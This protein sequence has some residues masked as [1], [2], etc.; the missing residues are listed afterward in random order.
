MRTALSHTAASAP[1]HYARVEEDFL[2]GVQWVATL[3]GRTTPACQVRDG[4][5][6]DLAHRPLGHNVP[7]LAGPGRLHWNCRSTSVPL[8]KSWREL[9]V[10]MNEIDPSTHAS[11]DG[12]VPAEITYREWLGAQSTQRQDE[13]LGSQRGR[14]LREG[15]LPVAAL[16][17]PGPLPHARAAARAQRA[18][19]RARWALKLQCSSIQSQCPRIATPP[20]TV[21]PM[22]PAAARRKR[23]ARLGQ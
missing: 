17:Q 22:T 7:W 4:L 6:Y 14:L 13:I 16:E 1:E 11:L 10:S 18:V 8:L 9:G 21:A 5:T 19:F 2:K 3:D 20:S 15:R 12:A 23:R